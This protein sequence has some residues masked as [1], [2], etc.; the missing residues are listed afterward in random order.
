MFNYE[1]CFEW[2]N[3]DYTFR[4]SDVKEAFKQAM[5]AKRRLGDSITINMRTIG[6]K[7]FVCFIH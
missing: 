3:G 6:K 4:Y 7:T 5:T 2:P 1:A